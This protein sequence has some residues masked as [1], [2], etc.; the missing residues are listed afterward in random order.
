MLCLRSS[1]VSVSAVR[2]KGDARVFEQLSWL[3]RAMLSYDMNWFRLAPKFQDSPVSIELW[4]ESSSDQDMSSRACRSAK[5]I[6]LVVA[7]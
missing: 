4:S 7:R 2:P 5:R 6:D 3:Q 1:A